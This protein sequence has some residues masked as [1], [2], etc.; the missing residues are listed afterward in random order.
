[1]PV[2]R[3]SDSTS[4]RRE[5]Y[6][7]KK[8]PNMACA[9]CKHRR[10]KCDRRDG[11]VSVCTECAQRGFV[12]VDSDKPVKALRRGR[13]IQALESTYSLASGLVVMSP[14]ASDTEGE[15][16][17]FATRPQPKFFASEFFRWLHLQFPLFDPQELPSRLNAASSSTTLDPG[18]H[19]IAHTLMAW[20]ASFGLDENGRGVIN[21]D[22][23]ERA[24]I[25][26]R[27]ENSNVLVRQCLDMVDRMGVLRK[28][29]FDGVRAILLLMPLTRDVMSEADRETMYR[30]ALLQAYHLSGLGCGSANSATEDANAAIMRAR[31][32]WYAHVSEGIVCGLR[33][34]PSSLPLIFDETCVES[35]KTSLSTTTFDA[36]LAASPITAGL[37]YK[38]TVAPIQLA[39]TCRL[40]HDLFAPRGG[41]KD[42]LEIRLQEVWSALESSWDEFDALKRSDADASEARA[43]DTDVFVSSWQI[44]IFEAYHTILIRLADLLSSVKR[45]E[46]HPSSNGRLQ[47]GG[48]NHGAPG[49]IEALLGVA[50]TKCAS[51]LSRV[52]GLIRRHV[53]DSTPL[54]KYNAGILADKGVFSAGTFLA[55]AGI[56]GR[57]SEVQDDLVSCVK[58]L[59]GMSCK[60]AYSEGNRL[61]G[62]LATLPDGSILI[63]ERPGTSGSS[64]SVGGSIPSGEE[65]VDTE[66]LDAWLS[67]VAYIN[68]VATPGTPS[69]HPLHPPPG[70]TV[71]APSPPLPTTMTHGNAALCGA[72]PHD[73][74]NPSRPRSNSSI[75]STHR[76]TTYTTGSHFRSSSSASSALTSPFSPPTHL[77]EGIRGAAHHQRKLQTHP[78]S[79]TIPSTTSSPFT[80]QP[81]MPVTSS[82]C[83][84]LS[85]TLTDSRPQTYNQYQ[86]PLVS[87]QQQ[88]LPSQWQSKEQ[89]AA[90]THGVGLNAIQID[91][92][93]MD[94]HEY[95]T[96]S[97]PINY[98][99]IELRPS[100]ATSTTSSSAGLMSALGLSVL[101]RNIHAANMTS[102]GDAIS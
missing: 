19:L 30:A 42:M 83:T 79:V 61:A 34:N 69:S 16:S 92:H 25:T 64:I 50:R 39:A 14:G 82:P 80:Y 54:L 21:V 12:C 75:H 23:D 70:M 3:A 76:N 66:V 5:R 53:R 40:I 96:S 93:A 47:N 100:S 48:S 20:A 65:K 98:D 71:P 94:F 31:L 6:N 27:R 74:N 57:S 55:E 56:K 41:P 90:V 84:Y 86:S 72:S 68:P 73:P 102:V 78:L 81:P 33:G 95:M 60:W 37:T 87:Q 1:M 10:V 101:Y 26:D 45:N 24:I 77:P 62:E 17:S 67:S 44:F 7:N 46:A 38:H 32:F 4:L 29:S 63:D 51:F 58:A 89:K 13:R 35:F 9:T 36:S 52:L 8:S 85:P 99:P 2:T 49:T 88:L 11:S 43:V 15:P 91:Q 97:S 22:V 28:M 59:R 18:L